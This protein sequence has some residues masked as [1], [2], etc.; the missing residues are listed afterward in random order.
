[1]RMPINR[2]SAA[3]RT[4]ADAGGPDPTAPAR[5]AGASRFPA[6]VRQR[7]GHWRWPA[8][9]ARHL[10]EHLG[11][12]SELSL[13]SSA[14]VHSGRADALA[15]RDARAHIAPPTCIGEIA[16]NRVP[17]ASVEHL[18]RRSAEFPADL[19]GIDRIASII[20]GSVVDIVDQARLRPGRVGMQLVE[21]CASSHR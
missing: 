9:R 18:L 17:Q 2:N 1:M 5:H 12:G 7:P 10:E 11:V 4:A 3:G 14:S 6:P 15:A 8:P 16:F 13:G 20:A 21:Q 19:G